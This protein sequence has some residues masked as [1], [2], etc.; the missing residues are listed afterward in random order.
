MQQENERLIELVSNAILLANCATVQLLYVVEWNLPA[1]R[2]N[3]ILGNK[4]RLNVQKG[5]SAI[6][7]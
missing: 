7:F 4:K 2:R 5:V 6:K 3:L 1:E